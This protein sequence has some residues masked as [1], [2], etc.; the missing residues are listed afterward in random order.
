MKNLTSKI[1]L[2]VVLLANLE[3][4]AQAQVAG[5]EIYL[6]PGENN[7]STPLSFRIHESALFDRICV[8]RVKAK[9]G[10]CYA[11]H[12]FHG[13]IAPKKNSAPQTSTA[14]PAALTC[15]SVGGQVV[16]LYAPDRSARSFCLFE[17]DSSLVDAWQLHHRLMSKKKVRK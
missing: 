5:D 17:K 7:Q 6:L 12:V 14:S 4:R 13:Q 16:A 3:G 11:L 8:D 10:G 15:L 2:G 1:L 9:S